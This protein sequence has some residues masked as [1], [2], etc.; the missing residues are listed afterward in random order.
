MDDILTDDILNFWGTRGSLPGPRI[1][2][3][4]GA[5]SKTLLKKFAAECSR[6]QQVPD[7][8]TF[9]ADCLFYEKSTFGGNT[10]CVEVKLGGERFIFDVG[11][12]ARQLGNNLI[13]EMFQKGGIKGIILL[14]H[15]H[16]DHIQGFPFFGPVFINKETG[17][18]IKNSFTIYGGTSYMENIEACL[19]QQ[20][21]YRVFP[22]TW[23]YLKHINHELLTETIGDMEKLSI[24]EV[25]VFTRMLN[26]P[27]GSLGY[28]LSYKGKVV[29]YTTDNEPFDRLTPHPPLVQLAKNAD[30]WITDCQYLWETYTGELGGLCRM[31]WGHSYPLAVA[32]AAIQANV[33]HVVLFHHDPTSTDEQ[34]AHIADEVR[35]ELDDRKASHILV[36]PAYDGMQLA[37]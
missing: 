23:A 31:G 2:T 1:A 20:M 7:V 22:V 19:R 34:I 24:G 8:D 14:S 12:G 37:L 15:T 35:R 4:I 33:K 26:H 16:W 13:A 32:M 25:D 10:S 9:L 29:T 18:G 21:E 11:S 6:T 27:G 3:D 17:K 5:K 30:V 28:R 36:S